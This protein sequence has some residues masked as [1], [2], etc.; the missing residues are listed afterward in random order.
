MSSKNL[1]NLSCK[2]FLKDKSCEQSYRQGI[3]KVTDLVD[4]VNRKTICKKT[5]VFPPGTRVFAIA[6]QRQRQLYRCTGCCVIGQ[7]H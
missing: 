5:V 4:R 2:N 7:T 6:V 1:L 3:K